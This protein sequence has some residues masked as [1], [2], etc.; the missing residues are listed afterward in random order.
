[1]EA[2]VFC[3][4]IAGRS[5]AS[6][7][8]RD[9]DCIAVMDIC[10]INAGHLLV[11]PV[12]HAT[13]LADLD[14]RVGGALF[15]AAQRLAAAIRRSGLKAEGIN[16]LLADG[17]AAGQEVFHVHLHVLPR[18]RGDGFGH[19]FPPHYGQ[20]APREQ[21]DANAGAVKTSLGAA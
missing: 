19:R 14:P 2:C 21:L 8:Y 10:P 12:K 15:G 9:D 11:L 17:E 3:E 1:M 4:I 18:F 16:L 6:V 13:Y 20:Q 7:V 5:Q